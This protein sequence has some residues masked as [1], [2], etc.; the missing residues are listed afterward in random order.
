[1]ESVLQDTSTYWMAIG[2]LWECE[3]NNSSFIRI[4][5]LLIDSEQILKVIR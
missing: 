2:A 3:K 1:M 4:N 5:D